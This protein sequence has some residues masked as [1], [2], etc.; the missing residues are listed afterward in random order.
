MAQNFQLLILQIKYK[1]EIVIDH[2]NFFKFSIDF[3]NSKFLFYLMKIINKLIK[4]IYI[5]KI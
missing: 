2:N 5:T 1:N 4:Q 3:L